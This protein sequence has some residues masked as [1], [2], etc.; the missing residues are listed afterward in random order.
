[1]R[2]KSQT[3][4]LAF[5]HA[6]AAILLVLCLAA[7]VAAAPFEDADAAYGSKGNYAVAVGLW[8]PQGVAEAQRLFLAEAQ[9]RLGALYY[10]GRVVSKNYADALRWWSLAASQGI[11]RAQFALGALYD[12]GQ[13]VQQNYAEAA[14]WYRLAADQ[15]LD[16]AQFNLGDLYQFGQGVPKDYAEAAKWSRLAADQ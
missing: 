11:D 9:H 12:N 15:G 3:V 14:K 10:F 13:G 7:P 4:K 16:R 5:K 1:M 8:F 6:F 2:A